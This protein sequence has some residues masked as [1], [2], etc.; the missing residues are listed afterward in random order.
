M[1]AVAGETVTLETYISDWD[2]NE[3]TDTSRFSFQWYR[4]TEDEEKL[5]SETGSSYTFLVEESDFYNEDDTGVWYRCEVTSG[6]LSD[7]CYF[8]ITNQ[9]SY[10]SIYGDTK[11]VYAGAK[12]TLTPE[13]YDYDFDDITDFSN[14]TFEWYK[15]TDYEV[16]PDEKIDCSGN[17]YSFVVSEKDFYK[18]ENE[19]VGYK[20][21][22]TFNGRTQECYFYLKDKAEYFSVF[23]GDVY[24]RPGDEITLSPSIEGYYGEE[25]TNTEKLTYEWY[26]VTENDDETQEEKLDVIQKDFTLTVKET[27]FCTEKNNNVEYKCVVKLGNESDECTFWIYNRDEYFEVSGEAP[28]TS[29]G[30]EITLCPVIR[31]YDANKVTDVS[32][33]T[34]EWYKHTYPEDEE[35]VEDLGHSGKSYTLKVSEKDFYLEKNDDV[36]YECLIIFGDQSFSAEFYVQKK[37]TTFY[38]ESAK[39]ISAALGESVTM[40]PTIYNS[41]RKKVDSNN[42]RFSFKW[43]QLKGMDEDAEWV[44]LNV[45]SPSYTIQ[46][47]TEYDCINGNRYDTF[48]R[49]DLYVDGEEMYSTRFYV[50]NKEYAYESPQRTILALEGDTVKLTPEIQDY[51]GN[52]VKDTSDLTY[53]WYGVGQDIGEQ[54]VLLS[55]GKTYEFKVTKDDFCSYLTDVTYYCNIYKDDI[56]VCTAG[57]A[58]VN[59]DTAMIVEG[60]DVYVAEGDKITLT[61]TIKDGYGKTVNLNDPTLTFRWYKGYSVILS[62][63]PSYTIDQVQTSDFYIDVRGWDFYVCYVEKDGKEIGDA[64]FR[65]INCTDHKYEKTV[66]KATTSKD[67][68][69]VETCSNCGATKT[70]V[71]PYPKTVALSKTAFT[72]NGKTQ[73]P[74]VTVTGSDGQKIASSNYSVAYSSG[75]KNVG[76]YTVTIT[77]KGNYSGT[78]KKTYD[79][80]PKGTS[81]SKLTAG[82]KSFSVKWKKQSSQTTG[83]EVQYSTDKNLKKGVKRVSITKN[84]TVSKSITKLKAK[85]KYYVRIRTYKTVKVSGKSVKLYSSWS[86][87]KSVKT[88]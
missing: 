54:N 47:L 9:E 25:F 17:S 88:K 83:Y 1:S 84:A 24:T 87:A 37:E 81:L 26:R 23:G 85:T 68:T 40:A 72:Y 62:K 49:C 15:V 6:D 7:Y 5:L 8:Y 43:Y 41:E 32:N 66:K 27:D 11:T 39:G 67:G 38:T 86:K 77:F 45:D 65:I 2:D 51:Y 50:Y 10:F 69:I 78:I 14:F 64:V 74:T 3:I 44:D 61:P 71:I 46:N 4:C 76:R 21:V 58:I 59:K 82:K 53:Q 22:A 31:D 13:I 80:V 12:V 33:F 63:Q 36:W 18:E 16:V 55:T 42:P 29:V 57:F 73:K 52:P 28:I 19:Y 30:Q 56:L 34:F 79:I 75:Q 48:Y 60:H 35:V 70:T 20:C